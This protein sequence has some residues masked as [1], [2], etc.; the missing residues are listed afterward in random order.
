MVPWQP[1]AA[2]ILS[3][4]TCQPPLVALSI[5]SN[6]HGMPFLQLGNLLLDGIPPSALLASGVVAEVH[7][8]ASTVPVTC[9]KQ[10][11]SGVNIQQSFVEVSITLQSS[12]EVGRKALCQ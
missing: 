1:M 6:V 3:V 11:G 8:A 5:C 7:V 10:A 4:L 9:T 12:A 2:C